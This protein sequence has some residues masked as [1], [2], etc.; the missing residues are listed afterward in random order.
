MQN[1]LALKKFIKSVVPLSSGFFGAVG[2]FLIFLPLP[3]LIGPMLINATL[4]LSGIKMHIHKVF[5]PPVFVIIGWYLGSKVSP[6]TLGNIFQWIPISIVLIIWMTLASILGSMYYK[7]IAKFD[8]LTAT[9]S[10]LPG[11]LAVIVSAIQDTKA[12]QKA[13]IISQSIRVFLVVISLPIIFHLT[14]DIPNNLNI[15]QIQGYP[16]NSVLDQTIQ[17][18][19]CASI[20]II[21]ITILKL[22]KIPSPYLLG[23]TLTSAFFFGTG[24]ITEP[25]PTPILMVTLYILGSLLGTRFSGSTW[26]EVIKLGSHGMFISILLLLFVTLGALIFSWIFGINFLS[27]FLAYIPGGVHEITIIAYTYGI[28]PLFVGFMHFIRIAVIT[29]SLP[30]IVVFLDRGSNT[31]DNFYIDNRYRPEQEAATQNIKPELYK[32]FQSVQDP[33]KNIPT[34]DH[35]QDAKPVYGHKVP[36]KPPAEQEDEHNDFGRESSDLFDNEILPNK[37]NN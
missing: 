20:S 12:N 11:A 22:L 17:W 25:L 2:G 14:L 16:S 33:L 23:G 21:L 30:L 36:A 26:K 10:A 24:Y 31:K 13:V 29:L 8:S 34:V 27:M 37:N 28:D 9:Y 19:L 18:L 7:K 3:A 6:D 1:K 15:T 5:L 35:S 32:E 4:C